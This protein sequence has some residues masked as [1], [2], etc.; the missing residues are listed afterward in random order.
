MGREWEQ[1][2]GKVE[3]RK[4]RGSTAATVRCTGHTRHTSVKAGPALSAWKGD[5]DIHFMGE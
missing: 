4:D 1:K 3:V 2:N 5:V